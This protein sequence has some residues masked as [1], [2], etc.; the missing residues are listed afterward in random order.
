MDL[1]TITGEFSCLISI[2]L[3]INFI[4]VAFV[5]PADLKFGSH[6]IKDYRNSYEVE[7]QG[8]KVKGQGHQ[9]QNCKNA[10]FQ[11]SI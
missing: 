10:S 5:G 11:P 1:K 9:G 3:T 4:K 6:I 2:S 8:R 7:G